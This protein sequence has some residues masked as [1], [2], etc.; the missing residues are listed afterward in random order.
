MR[1]SSKSTTWPASAIALLLCIAPPGLS[2]QGAVPGAGLAEEPAVR[3]AILDAVRARV[4][5]AADVVIDDLRFSVTGPAAGNLV[6]TPESGARLA[7][8]VRFSLSRRADR[9]GAPPKLAGTRPPR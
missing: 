9:A 5:T 3:L 4:G 1:C 2:G 6:A 7:C 8:P